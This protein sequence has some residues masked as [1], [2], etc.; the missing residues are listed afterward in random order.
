MNRKLASA[1]VLA[2]PWVLLLAV[3]SSDLLEFRFENLEKEVETIRIDLAK[4]KL[5]VSDLESHLRVQAGRNTLAE[6]S[7]SVKKQDTP[8]AKAKPKPKHP[9]E[10]SMEEQ[11]DYP[12]IASAPAGFRYLEPDFYIGNVHLFTPASVSMTMQ[13]SEGRSQSSSTNEFERRNGVVL[14]STGVNSNTSESTSKSA[15]CTVRKK[16]TITQTIMTGE[17]INRT[18]QT[19]TKATFQLTLYDGRQR[20]L[21]FADFTISNWP[22]KVRRPFK[23]VV[24]GVYAK[25]VA[26]WNIIFLQGSR[27]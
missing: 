16:L 20:V 1:I 6:L 14:R 19:Y 11:P 4:I 17:L 26:S 24:E 25:D 7:T 3:G 18:R 13:A 8:T 2:V 10:P 12:A 23:V 5:R 15:S 22:S 21:G 27:A 9:R